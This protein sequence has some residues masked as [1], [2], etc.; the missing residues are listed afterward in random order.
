[1]R[2]FLA[3]IIAIFFAGGALSAEMSPVKSSHHAAKKRMLFPADRKPFIFSC[4]YSDY[5]AR[6]YIGRPCN[7]NGQ[8]DDCCIAFKQK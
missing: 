5:C 8:C 7:D 1:M 4:E 6:T 3:M 2:I